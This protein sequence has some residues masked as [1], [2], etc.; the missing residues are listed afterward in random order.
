MK[1]GSLVEYKLSHPNTPL[2]RISPTERI[3]FPPKSDKISAAAHQTR[4]KIP[5]VG[6][7]HPDP[8]TSCFYRSL[9]VS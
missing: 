1:K 7:G 4:S 6:G 9:V 5:Q 3:C 8:V 2:F